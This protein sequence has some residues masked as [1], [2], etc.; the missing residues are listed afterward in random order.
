M[1]QTTFAALLLAAFGARA[2]AAQFKSTT[3]EQASDLASG[4]SAPAVYDGVHSLPVLEQM[5]MT[6]T[7]AKA[8]QNAPAAATPTLVA[9]RAPHFENVPMPQA[10][11]IV[12]LPR[13]EAPKGLPRGAAAPLGALVGMT[14]GLGMALGLSK[15]LA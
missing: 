5:A 9:P 2:S 14:A 15:V 11:E 4:Q 1:K 7:P 3:F 8:P 12:S 6:G 10:M 13:A